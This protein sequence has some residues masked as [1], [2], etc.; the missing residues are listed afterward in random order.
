MTGAIRGTSA[1]KT[2]QQL[3]L[4]SLKS[5]RWFRKFCHFYKIFND[6]SS[7]YL[8]NLILNFNRVHNTR[9]SY[10]IP[11][12]KVKYD[13]FKNFFLLLY[14]S[15]TS[16]TSTLEILQASMLLKRSF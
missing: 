6:K 8:F 14:Q 2:Y 10:N 11:T 4:G 1:E 16:L 3:G 12:I 9:L 13:Y 5:R 7:S 15:G